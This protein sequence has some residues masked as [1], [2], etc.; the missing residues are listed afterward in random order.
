MLEELT[1]QAGIGRQM[2]PTHVDF[3]QFLS[4]Y[5][6]YRPAIEDALDE[7]SQAFADLG[8]DPATGM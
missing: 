8:A 4:L 6:N 7:V 1:Y 5:L 3:H 2:V